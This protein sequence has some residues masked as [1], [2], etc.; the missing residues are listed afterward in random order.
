MSLPA[1][2]SGGSKQI[3]AG[4]TPSTTTPSVAPKQ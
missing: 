3:I 2:K 1:S 4:G